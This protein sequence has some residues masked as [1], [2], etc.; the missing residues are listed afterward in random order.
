MKNKFKQV[1]PSGQVFTTT[2]TALSHDGRGI[3]TSPKGKTIFIEGA[4]IQETVS[5]R[6]TKEH[7]R[8][9]EGVI[10]DVITASPE[11]VVPECVHYAICGGCSMQHISPTAQIEFKQ[12]VL[13][14]QLKHFGKVEPE[15]ILPPVSADIWG[16]RRKARIGVHYQ[17]NTQKIIIG[18]H[19]KASQTLA[20]LHSCLVL[21]QSIGLHFN[22]IIQVIESLSQRQHIP[23]LEVAIGDTKSALIFRVL[24]NLTV[25]D[26][27]R[28]SEFGKK[29]SLE[30][31]L[32]ANPPASL[33]KIWPLDE[34]LQL[35]Y[36]LSDFQVEMLFQPQDFT[37][38]NAQINRLMVK[39]ALA[40]LDPQANETILDLFCG[41]GNFTLPI[42]RFA[43]RV[44]GIEGSREMVTRAEKNAQHNKLDNTEFFAANLDIIPTVKPAWVKKNYDKILLDPP[45][46]GAKDIISVFPK[47]AAKR[48]LYVSCN[49]ATLARDAGILVHQQG[50]SL[51]SC[52]VINMF[53]HTS[54]IETMALFEK[55]KV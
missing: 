13:L 25:E 31:Y 44:V 39:Q 22:D 47:F 18:F 38:V 37:Q 17:E 52:G 43:K 5:Y 26:F 7:K 53:P 21:H 34:D 28:L 9:D 6:L 33:Q 51:R 30:I 23:Q 27:Q 55:T 40:L 20:E 50:Y 12:Q 54:H 35:S 10:V 24:K 48:I 49:P 15:N 46:T 11:R 32:E 36:A 41:L 45:R 3:A 16:Y 29:F 14:E 19:K 1:N 2:I 8:Y 42:A 4:L